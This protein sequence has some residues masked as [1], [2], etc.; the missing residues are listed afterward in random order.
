M[1]SVQCINARVSPY[2]TEICP[3][4]AGFLEDKRTLES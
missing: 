3:V 1:Y 4:M 2:A